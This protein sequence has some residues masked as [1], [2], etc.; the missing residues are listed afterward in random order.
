M[1]KAASQAR[2]SRGRDKNRRTPSDYGLAGKTSAI[3]LAGGKGERL[4]A[5][6]RD[7]CKPALPFGAAFRNIDFTL[8]N[9]V[10]SGIRRIGIATQHKPDTLLS[11]VDA[12]WS[13]AVRR[14]GE[15]LEVWPAE[16]R[17]PIV[18]YRGTADA[19]FRNLDLIGKHGSDLVL[20][21]AGDH[22]YQMDYRPMLEFHRA[23]NADVTIG[24]ID[25]PAADANQF[26]ILSLDDDARI[27]RFVEKPRTLEG[28]RASDRV[29]A[30]MGI[31]VF[32][33]AFLAQV[34][35]Q[36]AFSSESRH[37]FGGDIL[38][39][40]VGRAALY[41]YTFAGR[42]DNRPAYW[43][44]VGTPAAYW[45]AHLELLDDAPPLRLDDATWPMPAVC[46]RPAL[47]PGYKRAD[48][49]VGGR[50]LIAGNSAIDGVV[51][52]CVVFPGV[53]L[54]RGSLV[55]NSVVLPGA[56]IG[57]NCRLS[58]AIVD[59]GCRVPDD[60]VID[61]AWRGRAVRDEPVVLTNADFTSVPLHACA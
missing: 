5:L 25:V 7:V 43:R 23:R 40:L 57:R 15:F 33:T 59:T 27:A 18:G 6:T 47:T 55:E 60:T 41:A 19:V 2:S 52:R 49:S 32:S 14:S 42:G 50:S 4:G 26:G 46:G 21:L 12:V 35:R 30:S 53:R 44:D 29:P 16:S 38:P 28:F 45:R 48:G 1:L 11:H 58:G 51:H 31:Y 24:C 17:A 22:V 13:P 10:N 9:C 20:V 37:D 54:G 36:D 56:V 3:V 61:A 34:L 39:G 8:S